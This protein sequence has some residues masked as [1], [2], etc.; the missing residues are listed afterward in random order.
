VVDRNGNAMII[1][2]Q[3]DQNGKWEIRAVDGNNRV[4]WSALQGS[5]FQ[6][7]PGHK[8]I[9]ARG[10]IVYVAHQGR[11]SAIDGSNGRVLWEHRISRPLIMR[12][13]ELAIFDV[14]PGS[15]QGIVAFATEDAILTGVDRGTGRVVFQHALG[16]IRR[17]DVV[18]GIGICARK[19]AQVWLFRAPDGTA[20][21]DLNG[22]SPQYGDAFVLPGR[23]VVEMSSVELNGRDECG[24]GVFDLRTMQLATFHPAE[25]LD[26]SPGVAAIGAMNVIAVSGETQGSLV[27]VDPSRPPPKAGLFARTFS[28]SSGSGGARPLPLPG[29]RIMQ[30]V[31]VGSLC[32]I[33]LRADSG[34]RRVV[35]LDPTTMAIRYDS[36]VLPEDDPRSHDLVA[37]G[38]VL[39]Y[40]LRSCKS[41]KRAE[42]RAVS[43][44]TCQ[45]VMSHACTGIQDVTLLGPGT[46]GVRD[47]AEV[48]VLR[49]DGTRLAHFGSN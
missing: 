18:P 34:A 7:C 16:E 14:H 32:G 40:T 8:E 29:F 43:A 13:D 2:S 46:I 33:D 44:S 15:P 36:G 9:C 47:G 45:Q 28:I 37:S 27:I 42:V 1:G 6:T 49:V 24:A 26:F 23:I 11:L 19:H 10:G 5:S 4:L 31:G 39:V 25:A 35:L 41:G 22:R 38:D 17:I 30:L 21:L 3:V 20:V 48:T 12:D